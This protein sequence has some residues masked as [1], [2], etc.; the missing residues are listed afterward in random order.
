VLGVWKAYYIKWAFCCQFT[1]NFIY[2]LVSYN[3][4][5]LS[6]RYNKLE[7]VNS[8]REINREFAAFWDSWL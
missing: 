3:Y 6:V 1:A 4:I 5:V 7:F 2:E 8:V